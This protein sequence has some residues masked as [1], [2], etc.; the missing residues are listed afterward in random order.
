MMGPEDRDSLDLDDSHQH[1]PS[2]PYEGQDN[3]KVR[4]T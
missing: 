4:L 2:V 1:N 3:N